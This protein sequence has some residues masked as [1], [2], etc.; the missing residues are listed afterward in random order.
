MQKFTEH[1][2][3]NSIMLETEDGDTVAYAVNMN[4]AVIP[5]LT[6][7]RLAAAETDG[8]KIINDKRRYDKGEN[9]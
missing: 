9:K 4:G 6:A 3:A 2:L 7:A 5:L 8:I 1:K